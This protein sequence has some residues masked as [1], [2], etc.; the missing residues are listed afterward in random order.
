MRIRWVLMALS[1]VAQLSTAKPAP[2]LVMHEGSTIEAQKDG[3]VI[4][5]ISGRGYDRSYE[6]DGCSLKSKMDSRPQRFM[7]RLG[8]YD[9]ASTSGFS[10]FSLGSCKGISR[11]V[12][13][14]SQ[15]HFDDLQFAYEWIRR[16]QLGMGATGKTVWT[17]HGLLVSWNVVPGRIQLNVDVKLI[18]LNGH[19]PERLEGAADAAI[20]VVKNSSGQ[21]IHECAVVAKDVID[22]T[23]T[24]LEKDWRMVDEW[25]AQDKE[26]RE[27]AKKM[28]SK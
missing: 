26:R 2:E 12:V 9:P 13:E 3:L 18:C 28:N 10:L 16:Q 17:N 15:I 7:G 19:R 27:R 23:R 5:V 6:W 20:R 21:A 14:E 11:T 4:K 25:I 8:I 22:Q 24:Q 1:F